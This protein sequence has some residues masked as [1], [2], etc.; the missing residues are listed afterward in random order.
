MLTAKL[1]PSP[2]A[3]V[4]A[5][6]CSFAD[7]AHWPEAFY[8]LETWID[9]HPR[10]MRA[11]KYIDLYFFSRPNEEPQDQFWVA[12]EVTGHVEINEPDM[13]I[14][15]LESGEVWQY[16]LEAGKYFQLDW[17]Q[18]DIAAKA[19]SQEVPGDYAPT[20][21]IRIGWEE[22]QL[23]SISLEFFRMISIS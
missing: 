4:I 13:A 20:W 16:P 7:R 11:H 2:A 18:W 23:I 15:D 9:H 6:R 17:S 10:L 3:R 12:R 8:G 21:R 22:Q 14:T 1:I 5:K 19:I